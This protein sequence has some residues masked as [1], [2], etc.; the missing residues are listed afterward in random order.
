M[1]S[2]AV[3]D[4]GHHTFGAQSLTALIG[5]AAQVEEEHL[6]VEAHTLVEAEAWPVAASVSRPPR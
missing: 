3:D 6:S 5:G 2:I 1:P 4:V